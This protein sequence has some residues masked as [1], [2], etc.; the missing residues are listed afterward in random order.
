[1]LEIFFFPDNKISDTYVVL[2]YFNLKSIT[3][4]KTIYAIISGRAKS[5]CN[6]IVLSDSG[7]AILVNDERRH[8][9]IMVIGKGLIDLPNSNKF[10]KI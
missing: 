10:R 8:I 2:T 9:Y 4:L 1:M 3:I 7:G 6:Y 5:R